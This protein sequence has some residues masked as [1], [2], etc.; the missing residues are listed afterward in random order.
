VTGNGASRRGV[1]IAVVILLFVALA[2]G[3]FLSIGKERLRSGAKVETP[4]T[5]ETPKTNFEAANSWKKFVSSTRA[6]C[7]EVEPKCSL[8]YAALHEEGGQSFGVI[9]IGWK[10]SEYAADLFRYDPRQKD[11]IV[12]PT[13]QTESGYEEVD[14]ATASRAWG[15]PQSTLSE[16]IKAANDA[17]HKKYGGGG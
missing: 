15:V 5:H 13:H 9:V 11:W 17:M 2:A 3:V 6:K 1:W 12:A 4:T 8:D 7:E 14:T 16:W 10:D